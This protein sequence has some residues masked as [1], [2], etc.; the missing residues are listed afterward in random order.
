MNR[1]LLLSFSLCLCFGVAAAKPIRVI[2]T[3][4]VVQD[5]GD[6]IAGINVTLSST[7]WTQ[8]LPYHTTRRAAVLQ[9]LSTAAGTVCIST[10]STT[11]LACNGSSTS[12]MA[13][14]EPGAALEVAST[15]KTPLYGRVWDAVA[16]VIVYGLKSADSGD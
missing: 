10:F 14:L 12:P 1:I 8:I 4:P 2:T 15:T 16:S 3:T 7:T 9:T 6:S 5:D 11:A 13:I